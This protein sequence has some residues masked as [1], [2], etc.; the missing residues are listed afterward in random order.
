MVLKEHC[1]HPHITHHL[2]TLQEMC[3]CFPVRTFRFMVTTKQW[4]WF[5]CMHM[6]ARPCKKAVGT[7]FQYHH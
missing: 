2:G 4:L 7:E 6:L 5:Y 1:W 3:V